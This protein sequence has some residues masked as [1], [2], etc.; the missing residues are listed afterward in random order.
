M[1]DANLVSSQNLW[2]GIFDFNDENKTHKNWSCLKENDRDGIWNPIEQKTTRNCGNEII[3]SKQNERV[4]TR[5]TDKIKNDCFPDEDL[6]TK[7]DV[8]NMIT[9]V[10]DKAIKAISP[11]VVNECISKSLKKLTGWAASLKD[12]AINTFFKRR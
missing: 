2:H 9:E 5:E 7:V 12:F 1:A 8:R 6:P 11:Q 3:Q 4:K 10:L